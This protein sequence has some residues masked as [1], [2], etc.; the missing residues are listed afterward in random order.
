MDELAS[1][2]IGVARVVSY[3][4]GLDVDESDFLFS[5]AEDESTLAVFLYLEDVRDGRR[6]VEAA[7]SC[8]ARKPVMALKAGKTGAALSAARSHTGALAGRYE[9]F[10]A[11]FKK[12]SVGELS[13]Y[14]EFMDAVR[15][16]SSF[17]KSAG[18]RTLII[19][20]GGG[21]G[22]AIAD[23]CIAAGLTVDALTEEKKEELGSIL[24]PY[25]T[26][27]NPLDLTGSAT[28]EWF[29]LCLSKTIDDYDI[30]IV[31]ALWGP[32]EITERLP[33]LLGRAAR[34]SGKPVVICSP[35]GEFTRLRRVL[36]EREGLPVFP[37][38]E[39]A[40]RAA[41]VLER[42]GAASP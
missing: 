26:V 28:D 7:R 10:R 27:S 13:G 8:S 6:F 23:E 4:N 30:A 11:A 17:R 25:F 31:A 37:T 5:L 21:M 1:E 9:L 41:A 40:V 29:T 38:P 16:L 20:D 34:K 39:A 22:V 32:P 2:G 3:G 24:P 12:A 15:A 33:S 35:G 19:T 36:F 18:K 14:E 42:A